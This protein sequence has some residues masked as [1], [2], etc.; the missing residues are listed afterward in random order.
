MPRP[1][2]AY[3]RVYEPLSALE[4]ALADQVRR[5]LEKGPLSRADVGDR[6]RELW[7]RSQLASDRR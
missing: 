7:L 4:P 5:A 6:E 1:F 3:L 2:V